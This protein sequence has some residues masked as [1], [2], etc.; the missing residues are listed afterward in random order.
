M[1]TPLQP[2]R[3]QW[4]PQYLPFG[5]VDFVDATGTRSGARG[6]VA[7][8]SRSLPNWPILFV[9]IRISNLFDLPENPT[10]LDIQTYEA[11]KRFLDAEQTVRINLSQQNITAEAT[12]QSQV[13]GNGGQYWSP[14]PVPFPM[15]GGNTIAVDITRQTPYPQINDADVLPTCH[16][17]I[18]AL[19][20]RMSEQTIPPQRIAGYDAADFVPANGG[21]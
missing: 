19:Q 3:A 12:L 9:G 7:T 1:P 20:A 6:A 18:I 10:A 16:G 4:F 8:L 5:P 21:G 11:A 17:S 15:A 13:T 14:L 2:L